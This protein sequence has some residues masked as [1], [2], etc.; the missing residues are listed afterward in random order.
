VVY[1]VTVA[2]NLSGRTSGSFKLTD[3]VDG[4]P[5]SVRPTAM[6]PGQGGEVLEFREDS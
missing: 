3:S 4:L 2:E 6:L 1:L 5:L